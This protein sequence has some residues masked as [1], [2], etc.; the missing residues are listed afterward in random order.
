MG[1]NIL[2][3]SDLHLGTCAFDDQL[4]VI[5]KIC[6]ALKTNSWQ[7]DTVIFTGDIFDKA[8]DKLKGKKIV[9][10]AV[11][12]FNYLLEKISEEQKPHTIAREDFLFVPG[13]HDMCFRDTK[14]VWKIYDHFLKK[15]YER[16][17]CYYNDL[18]M[19]IKQ[20]DEKKILYLGF[21]S[22]NCNMQKVEI[23]EEQFQKV[24]KL[25]IESM[26]KYH[27]F[28]VI[29]FTHHPFYLFK[30]I[31][32]GKDGMISNGEEFKRKLARWDTSVVLHGHKHFAKS[33]IHR[34]RGDVIKVVAAPTVCG[35]DSNVSFNVV[36]IENKENIKVYGASP[37]PDN[38]KFQITEREDAK[39]EGLLCEGLEAL[40]CYPVNDMGQLGE[41]CD[42]VIELMNEL[43]IMYKSWNLLQITANKDMLLLCIKYKVAKRKNF[44]LCS[45]IKEELRRIYKKDNLQDV[46]E[47]IIPILDGNIENII[48]EKTL[49]NELQINTEAK[50]YV[51]YAIVAAFFVDLY[52][53]L[54]ELQENV[55]GIQ[56]IENG[57]YYDYTCKYMFIQ[58]KCDNVDAYTRAVKEVKSYSVRFH[59][60]EEY[61]YCVKLNIKDI[62]PNIEQADNGSAEYYDFNAYVPRLIPL[63]TGTNIY[64]SDLA[65]VRELVQN[66][67]DAISFRERR[68]TSD[69]PR[70]IYIRIGYNEE[71]PFFSIR[72]YG[73]GMGLEVIKLYFTT[74]GRSYYKEHESGIDENIHYNS[75][76]NFGVGFLSVFRLCSKIEVKTKHYIEQEC[77][78]LEMRDGQDYLIFKHEDDGEFD[79][80]TQI[81]GEFK[82]AGIKTDIISDI[83]RYISRIMKD[84]KYKIKIEGEG[85]I[86][87]IES[88][89]VRR[90][91]CAYKIFI[92][93]NEDDNIVGRAK[94]N[95]DVVIDD[96]NADRH[97]MLIRMLQK[98]NTDRHGRSTSI[99]NAG[100]LMQN[101]SIKD[102]WDEVEADCGKN[103][104][105]ND[106]T[107]NFPPNWLKV[108]VSREKATGFLKTANEAEYQLR[109]SSRLKI[110]ES[111]NS[112]EEVLRKANVS[113]GAYLELNDFIASLAGNRI[114]KKIKLAIKFKQNEISFCIRMSGD[115]EESK[116]KLIRV[117]SYDEE[118]RQAHQSLISSFQENLS[119]EI[120]E[121]IISRFSDNSEILG[122]LGMTNWGIDRKQYLPIVL[123]ACLESEETQEKSRYLEMNRK[124]ELL[125]EE[126]I[127][128]EC[129]VKDIFPGD[130]NQELFSI[131]YDRGSHVDVKVETSELKVRVSLIAEEYG[132][133]KGIEA[134][135][136]IRD[137]I[138]LKEYS[139]YFKNDKN[140]NKI[141]DIVRDKYNS[142]KRDIKR[143][144]D[145]ENKEDLIDVYMIAACYMGGLLEVPNEYLAEEIGELGETKELKKYNWVLDCGLEIIYMWKLSEYKEYKD[146]KY[147]VLR[148]QGKLIWPPDE[149][150]R[151][152]HLKLLE[153]KNIRMEKWYILCFTE[154]LSWLA[155]YNEDQLTKKIKEIAYV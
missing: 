108:D 147:D 115:I 22:N 121:G 21:N 76:S 63:L 119:A 75:I 83:P 6:Q 151:K 69:Y 10:Q 99:L 82:V 122:K 64:S 105:Y 142:L 44:N 90:E 70:E 154:L 101:T 20:D 27:E 117:Y 29:A 48:I 61:F 66:A 14:D 41:K 96:C 145:M 58:L 49:R 135:E 85:E 87:P 42:H 84:I 103:F 137:K 120:F 5:D 40:G 106:I 50:I 45:G 98:E 2:H 35:K 112:L 141:K 93:F 88:R 139:R 67:I 81:T 73:I 131:K 34:L 127:M 124:I 28:I 62:L 128:A 134:H 15:F 33:G 1:I 77:Y 92:P 104:R 153:L 123:A 130:E 78:K 7:I 46:V 152:R 79:I 102:I 143:V 144:Y 91:P 100:I 132:A 51:S 55:D 57:I 140:N 89:R 36:K 107:I 32:P 38:G 95:E 110:Q 43:Y 17:P 146:K 60:L 39:T 11:N 31:C 25:M 97:G 30:E 8:S 68:D 155:R 13:N 37:S 54:D 111:F 86:I 26:E 118:G 47:K 56:K 126:T 4:T 136:F 12:I 138:I 150:T 23:E 52:F 94:S 80:G 53:K 114:P 71:I 74:L 113:V 125:I 24:D 3:I 59:I 72:D 65:F 149:E 18:H 109:K 148:E 129:S 16:M 9:D 133:E 116:G 19:V